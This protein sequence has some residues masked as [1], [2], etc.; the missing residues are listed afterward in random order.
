MADDADK[1]WPSGLTLK[2]AEEVHTQL[3]LG[4]RM[5]GGLA[6]VAH[7]LTAVATPWLG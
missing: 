1:V 2:E 7:V 6:V 5:F 4:T 3:I